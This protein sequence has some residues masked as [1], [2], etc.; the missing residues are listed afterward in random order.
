MMQA[1][2]QMRVDELDATGGDAESNDYDYRESLLQNGNQV[3]GDFSIS[4]NDYMTLIPMTLT[5]DTPYVIGLD[6]Q[7]TFVNPKSAHMEAAVNLLKCQVEGMDMTQQYVMLADM[8]EP[9]LNPY[10][11]QSVKSAQEW[12]ETLEK[13]L[14]EADDADKKDIQ[15]NID[16]QKEYMSTMEEKEKYSITADQLTYYQQQIAPKM[17]VN[18]RP[19]IPARRTTPQAS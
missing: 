19:S 11:D 2:E 13:Q 18:D 3:V 14:A 5:A 7:V 9:M 15:S 17:F 1:L 4:T 6:M 8:T 12:L 16:A 10:Y